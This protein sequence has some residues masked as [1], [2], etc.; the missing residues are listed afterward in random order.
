M[1]AMENTSET[2]IS[3][4]P[5]TT[6]ITT[7]TSDSWKYRRRFLIAQTV[8]DMA[9]IIIA[10]LVAKNENVAEIGIIMAFGSLTAIFGFYVAG[11]V[12]DDH[13]YRL[14]QLKGMSISKGTSPGDGSP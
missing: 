12:W 7:S 13:S 11:T 14:F 4:E 5:P 10:L 6:T 1:P 8:F 9:V 3:D 2:K